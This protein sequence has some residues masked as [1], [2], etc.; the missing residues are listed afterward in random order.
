MFAAKR[1]LSIRLAVVGFLILGGCGTST[2][3]PDAGSPS[4]AFVGNWK[5]TTTITAGGETSTYD[6]GSIGITAA[7]P[8][9]IDVGLCVNG[10]PSVATLMTAT[11]VT[12]ESSDCGAMTFNGHCAATDVSITGGTGTLNGATLTMTI[13]GTASGCGYNPDTFTF[14]FT[15]MK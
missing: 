10:S 6:Q 3:L 13:E 14:S 1:G 8:D 9:S 11:T 5:G 15:G 7:G 2:S 12:L 4:D